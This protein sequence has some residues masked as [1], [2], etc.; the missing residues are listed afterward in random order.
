[1]LH[2]SKCVATLKMCLLLTALFFYR[3][4]ANLSKANRRLEK[5]LKEATLNIEE[6]RRNTD[7]YREQVIT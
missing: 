6:E 2:L 7:Q 5:K 4:R 3:E 1:M